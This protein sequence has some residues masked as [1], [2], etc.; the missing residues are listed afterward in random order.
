MPV[1]RWSY[2]YFHTDMDA[3]EFVDDSRK[4]ALQMNPQCQEIR[5]DEHACGAT[6]GH[7]VHGRG[8]IGFGEFEKGGLHK[9]KTALPSHFRG[10]H[11]YRF[12]GFFNTGPVGENN[13]SCHPAPLT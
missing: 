3:R 4:V 5:K 8:Q 10:Y 6:P 1:E 12:I 11:P 2:T 13:D 9:W 7:T